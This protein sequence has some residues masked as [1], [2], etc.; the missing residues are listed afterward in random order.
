M[1]DYINNSLHL[2]QKYAWIF[3]SGHYLFQGE[4]SSRKTV[5]SEE[6]IMYKN[7]YEYIFKAKLDIPQ[8]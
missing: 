5:S 3:V 7:K 2:V 1:M 4:W 6:M 8:F